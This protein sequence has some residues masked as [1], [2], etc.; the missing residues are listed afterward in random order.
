MEMK[1]YAHDYYAVDTISIAT[2]MSSHEINIFI[3][4]DILSAGTSR[5]PELF[6]ERRNI[7]FPPEKLG[8][9]CT[10]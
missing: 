7:V 4:K 1:I 2:T 3:F 5:D 10:F 9:K 8:S 6:E